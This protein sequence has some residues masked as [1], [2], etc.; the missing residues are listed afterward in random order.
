MCGFLPLVQEGAV[1]QAL[2]RLD[3]CEK[4]LGVCVFEGEGKAG[5]EGPEK[6][7]SRRLRIAGVDGKGCLSLHHISCLRN[8]P[9]IDP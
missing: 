4:V 5:W 2:I 7:Q 1:D 9:A 8:L 3:C 6:L